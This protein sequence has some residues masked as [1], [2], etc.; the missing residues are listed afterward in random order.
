M[1]DLKKY[2][3]NNNKNR[4][5]HNNIILNVLYIYATLHI[6]FKNKILLSSLKTYK[7]VV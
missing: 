6:L 2:N 3:N 1:F 4:T 7:I 5:K